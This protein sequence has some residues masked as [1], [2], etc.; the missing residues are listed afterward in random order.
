[1][2]GGGTDTRF[3]EPLPLRQGAR[4]DNG[5]ITGTPYWPRRSRRSGAASEGI[6]RDGDRRLAPSAGSLEIPPDAY[7][8]SSS[9]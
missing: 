2:F 9:A 3:R 6:F 4:S 5:G 1:M 8:S 7:S